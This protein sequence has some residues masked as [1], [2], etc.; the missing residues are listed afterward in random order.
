VKVNRLEDLAFRVEGLL[1][2][3]RLAALA[4]AAQALGRPHAARDVCAAVAKRLAH[5]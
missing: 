4:G 3:A 5:S 2:S 1:G